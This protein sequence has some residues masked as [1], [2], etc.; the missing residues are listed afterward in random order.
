MIRYIFIVALLACLGCDSRPELTWQYQ[1]TS[2][3][4]V[5]AMTK[6]LSDQFHDEVK[7]KDAELPLLAVYKAPTYCVY[8]ALLDTIA[9]ADQGEV[10]GLQNPSVPPQTHTCDG[11]LLITLPGTKRATTFIYKQGVPHVLTLIFVADPGK[12]VPQYSFEELCA[13]A[14]N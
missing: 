7:P 10:L 11:K 4:K 12:E 13:L 1:A 5:L 9:F 3:E 14:K 8:T 6:E 2:Q